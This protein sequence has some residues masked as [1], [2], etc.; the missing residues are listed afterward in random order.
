VLE[1]VTA[2]VPTELV[3]YKLVLCDTRDTSILIVDTSIAEVT[4]YRGIS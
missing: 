4:I 1:K 3:L 2:A